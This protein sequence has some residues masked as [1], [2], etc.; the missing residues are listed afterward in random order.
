MGERTTHHSFPASSGIV[1]IVCCPISSD[2]L[3]CRLGWRPSDRCE[4]SLS[5]ENLLDERRPEYG[6][7]G[8]ARVE[9]KRGVYGKFARR[10]Q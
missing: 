7:P 6:I 8:P 2:E 1:R 4:L 3:N 9:L 5:G 10:F